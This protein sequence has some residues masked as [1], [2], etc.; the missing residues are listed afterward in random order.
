MRIAVAGKGGAG[1]TTIAATLARLL[2]RDGYCVTA[3]DD[4]PNPNLAVALGVPA[5]ERETMRRVPREVLT[6]RRDER[7]EP[8]LALARPFE[9]VVK[10]FGVCGPDGVSTVVMTGVV[11]PGS[12]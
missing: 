11:E 6:E 1:K 4:D 10:E 5:E 2:A 3:I 12:G 8:R 9:E 7:G